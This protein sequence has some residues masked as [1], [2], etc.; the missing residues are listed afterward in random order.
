M[1]DKGRLADGC[2]QQSTSPHA[3]VG[4]EHVGAC[5]YNISMLKMLTP[6]AMIPGACRLY[7]GGG[8]N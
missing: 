8:H 1:L 7:V 4:C 6:W 2:N 5:Q 3:V